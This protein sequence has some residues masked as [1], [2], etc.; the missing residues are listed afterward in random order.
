MVD[1]PIPQP[2][3]VTAEQ[4]NPK[5]SSGD[6][7]RSGEYVAKGSEKLAQGI[8]ELGQGLGKLAVPF[9]EQ[10][11]AAAGM[12][13]V[14]RNADGTPFIANQ[15]NS[16]LFGQAGE[17]YA[18][19]VTAGH[20][21]ALRQQ[22][23]QDMTQMRLAHQGDPN[24]FITAAGEY[25]DKIAAANPGVVGVHAQQYANSV[26]VQHF[27]N[28][29]DQLGKIH[30]ESALQTLQSRL[31]TQENLIDGLAA[32]GAIGSPQY[33]QALVER[34]SI[35]QHMIDNPLSKYTEEQRKNDDV[36]FDLKIKGAEVTGRKRA[37][38]LRTGNYPQVLREANDEINA[39]VGPS[40]D[41][42]NK[43]LGEVG[44][45]LR[46]LAGA[47]GQQNFDL[48]NHAEGLIDTSHLYGG[49]TDAQFDAEVN[50]LRQNR[51]VGEAAKVQ[52]A[53]YLQAYKLKAGSGS[54]QDAAD[55]LTAA[56]DYVQTQ[57]AGSAGGTV[58][59]PPGGFEAAASRTLGFEGGLNEHDTNGYPV[60]FGINQKAHPEVDVHNITREQARQIYKKD[61]WDAIGADSLPANMQ[62]AAFDTAILAGAPRARQMLDQAG[63]DPNKL[64]DLR[65][66]Y[67]DT[68][69]RQYPKVYGGVEA[70]WNKRVADLRADVAAGGA[71]GG[72]EPGDAPGGQP[73]AFKSLLDS[74]QKYH[75]LLTASTWA[76]MKTAWDQGFQPS[77][78]EMAGL[79]TLA[80]LATDDKLNG[81]IKERLLIQEKTDDFKKQPISWQQDML[82]IEK[83][84][85]EG[86]QL[87]SL[88]RD[89]M[90]KAEGVTKRGAELAATDPVGW[91]AWKGQTGPGIPQIGPLDTGSQQG[92]AAGLK[93][94]IAVKNMAKINPATGQQ[95]DAVG[96]S[97]LSPTDKRQLASAI[98]SGPGQQ[99]GMILDTLGSSL[100]T[101]ELDP[102]I[103]DPQFKQAVLAAAKSTDP[104]RMKAG[105]SFLDGRFK[106]DP[107]HFDANFPGAHSDLSMYQTLLGSHSTEEIAKMMNMARDPQ[108]VKAREA[109]TLAADTKL[110]DVTDAD[111]A[112]KLSTFSLIN[113][114]TWIG[115]VKAKAPAPE[116]IADTP[117]YFGQDYRNAYREQYTMLPDEA[118]AEKHALE[119]MQMTWGVSSVNGN[120][121]MR[122][123]PE[124]S[125]GPIGGSYDWMTKQL[126]D[127]VRERTGA[128]RLVPG[129]TSDIVRTSLG[130]GAIR[131]QTAADQEALREFA[132]PRTIVADD[133]TE[134]ELGAN[135]QPSYAVGIQDRDGHYQQLMEADHVT[136][137]RFKPDDST[138]ALRDR[139]EWQKRS[140]EI[141]ALGAI[142]VLP[143]QL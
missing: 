89:I 22:I 40:Q 122:H 21:A 41:Q 35:Q 48:T 135:K 26:S 70:T 44:S 45:H 98:S 105:M 20:G 90:Q 60:N 23:D 80:P 97:P 39:L 12:G 17:A 137:Y 66:Q 94:R 27:D 28:M 33:Q 8:D 101:A 74:V 119:R 64:L 7:A 87:N 57:L 77:P 59:T 100:T 131:P 5:I 10:A 63:G 50:N 73:A 81:E 38:Y 67:Q 123:P 43:M 24:T 32:Q 134:R 93:D 2:Q 141:R 126:D 139:E 15:G 118:G 96:N 85:A 108:Q 51:L 11:G 42:K 18:A 88:Q 102:V 114:M 46:A 112:S 72:T 69:V 110:K 68:L 124:A 75:N 132:A 19:A 140:R 138:P 142:G 29:A 107:Q 56:R 55:A 117:A 103:A 120:Q 111:I 104:D 91:M 9:A 99:A 86:G 106:N 109:R 125:Y 78:Q 16:L 14:T 53:K 52:A 3:L 25:A 92:L 76:G 115:G 79:K 4:P 37:E 58:G 47:R 136:P 30:V 31:T 129:K 61:Y 1:L 54:P 95:D 130:M 34:A 113:P 36:N 133:Q 83:T 82:A 127:A 6:I 128:Q 84:M 62:S 121:L 116:T 49:V 71:T 143:G 13:K 65:Q